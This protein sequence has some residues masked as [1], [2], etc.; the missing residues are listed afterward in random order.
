[1]LDETGADP[2]AVTATDTVDLAGVAGAI[3]LLDETGDTTATVIGDTL[4]VRVTDADLDTTGAADTTTVTATS[5]T[6]ATGLTALTLTETGTNTGIFEGTFTIIA[7]TT[8]GTSLQVTVGDTI[9][10]T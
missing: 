10:A 1:M 6:D 4:R 3:V 2:A 5:S 9:T 8:T 7:G